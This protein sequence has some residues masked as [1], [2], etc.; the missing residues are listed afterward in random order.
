[1][2]LLVPI[3]P[4][5]QPALVSVPHAHAH[6]HAAADMCRVEAVC[7]VPCVTGSSSLHCVQSNS[8][9][10]AA[11]GGA[12]GAG[13]KFLVQEVHHGLLQH[14]LHPVQA[15]EMPEHCGTAHFACHAGCHTRH[16]FLT[17]ARSGV[18]PAAGW[19]LST[20]RQDHGGCRSQ[21]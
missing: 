14:F 10:L 15:A 12:K 3:K 1:M 8:G 7:A 9:M 17:A 6:F 21:R 13:A 2:P 11:S 18:E 4:V 20:V 19:Q 16:M 5:Q